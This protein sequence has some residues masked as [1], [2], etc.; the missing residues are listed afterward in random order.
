MN[1]AAPKR[2]PMYAATMK[3]S[4]GPVISPGIRAAIPIAAAGPIN[5]PAR[6]P[7]RTPASDAMAI[8][9]R[10]ATAGPSTKRSTPASR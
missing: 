8:G 2:T 4:R 5:S 10:V 7:I 1:A 9:R 3:P 6:A